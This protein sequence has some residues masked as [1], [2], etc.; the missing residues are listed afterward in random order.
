VKIAVLSPHQDDAAFSLSLAIGIWLGRG[1]KV[2]VVNCFTRSEAAPFSDADS[3]HANDRMTYVTALRRKEDERWRKQFGTKLQCLDLNLKDG[4][5]RL[6]CG[7]DE[8]SRV[9]IKVGDKALG[10]IAKAL[11]EIKPGAVVL[12]LSLGDHVDHRTARAA[13]FDFLQERTDLPYAFY[14]E[15]PDGYEEAS[16]G[17]EIEDA[18]AATGVQL[19]V[20]LLPVFAGGAVEA[21]AATRQKLRLVLQYDSQIGDAT[22]E[23]IAGVCKRYEGRERLWG[24]TA[25][26]ALEAGS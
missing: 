17:D 5:L 21:M 16:L 7:V 20:E 26:R 13:G 25:W 19:S 11:E 15:L 14:E 8:V 1:H 2:D 22:A 4:P 3:V 23:K 24:N 18:V 12:P 10:R 6:R 9:P